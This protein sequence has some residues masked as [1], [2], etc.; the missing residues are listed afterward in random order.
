MEK[1]VPDRIERQVVLQAPRSRV[2]QALT[3]VQQLNEW[4][5]VQMRGEIIPGGRLS[6]PITFPGYEHATIEAVVERVEPEHHLSWRW[7]PHPVE[8]GMDYTKEPTTLVT[9]ELE[10]VAGGT[11]LTVVESGFHQ[12]PVVRRAKAYESNEGGWT[13]VVQSIEKTMHAMASR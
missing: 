2:W 3:D 9:F 8:K 11:K 5:H 10:D 12:V 1:S 4:F 13:E 6:G 7:C